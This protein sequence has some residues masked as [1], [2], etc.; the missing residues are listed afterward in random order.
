VPMHRGRIEQGR[1]KERRGAVV[2]LVELIVAS[3]IHRVVLWRQWNE[4][5]SIITKS[6]C[7]QMI[8]T[9]DSKEELY[10]H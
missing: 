4:Q 10:C 7:T 5:T 6:E 3:Y 1:K 2:S 9:H 8:V